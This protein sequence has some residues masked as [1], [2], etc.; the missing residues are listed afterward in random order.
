MLFSMDDLYALEFDEETEKRLAVYLQHDE[1]LDPLPQDTDKQ[2]SICLEE[3][4]IPGHI[5]LRYCD[6]AEELIKGQLWRYSGWNG[7]YFE[8]S[9]QIS[10][11][12]HSLH[13]SPLYKW[14]FTI[15]PVVFYHQ[16]GK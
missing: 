12:V 15:G 1:H 4:D 11:L 8:H 14:A 7:R 10:G 13:Y 5:K 2:P 9:E 6:K 3:D 16:L